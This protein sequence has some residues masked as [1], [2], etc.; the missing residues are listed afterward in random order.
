MGSTFNRALDRCVMRLV[1]PSAG[2]PAPGS[3][4][5][6][7]PGRVVRG[8]PER[9]LSARS[10]PLRSRSSGQAAE[11]GAGRGD[12]GARDLV[13]TDEGVPVDGGTGAAQQIAQALGGGVGQ[14][15]VAAAV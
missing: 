3:A 4:C 9:R 10:L 5:S 11:E 12:H 7:A 6:N 15:R 2:V 8:A 14:Q 13:A 1:M